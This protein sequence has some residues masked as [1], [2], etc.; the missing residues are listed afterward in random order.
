ALEEAGRLSAPSRRGVYAYAAHDL[1]T[2][3][4]RLGSDARNR[5]EAIAGKL[6]AECH[7]LDADLQSLLDEA[8][9]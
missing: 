3:T 2:I 9:I 5:A 8:G 7:R 6:H 1:S 4:S